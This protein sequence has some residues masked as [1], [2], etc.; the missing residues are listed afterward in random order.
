LKIFFLFIHISEVLTNVWVPQQNYSFPIADKNKNRGLRFQ[1][2][3]LTE[4]EWLTYSELKMGAFYK[5]CTVF[6]KS[7]GVNNQLLGQL[8]VRV[9]DE[10]KNAKQVFII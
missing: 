6:A 3:W 9:L 7:G 8:A 1:Y 5:F 4:F 2:K 10:W